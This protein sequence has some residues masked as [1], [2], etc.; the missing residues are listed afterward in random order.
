M[1]ILNARLGQAESRSLT[2]TPRIRPITPASLEGGAVQVGIDV[3]TPAL[4]Q[5]ANDSMGLASP[6]TATFGATPQIGNTLIAV[7]FSRG[8]TNVPVTPSGWT[9]HAEGEVIGA[10]FDGGRQ[11]FFYKTAGASESVN[12]TI[13]TSAT[14]KS[15]YIAEWSGLGAPDDAVEVNNVA[16][17]TSMTVGTITPSAARGV[18]FAGFNQSSRQQT[19][20]MTAGFTESYTDIIDASGPSQ[21]FGYHI[22]D[23]FAGPYTA[24]CTSSQSR[25]YG[26]YVLSFAAA[27]NEVVWYP[28]PQANDGDDATSAYGDIAVGPCIRVYLEVERLIYRMELDIGQETAGTTAYELYGTDDASF[29]TS[30]LLGTLTFTATGGVHAGLNRPVVGA[31]RVVPVLRDTARLG[32]WRRARSLRAADVLVGVIG[33]WRHRSPAA[34]G[35][36]QRGD[37]HPASSVTVADGDEW[38]DS[39]PT[40]SRRGWPSWRPR[41]SAIPAT[42]T[43]AAPRRSTRPSAGT[44]ARLT[45]TAR[46]P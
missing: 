13:S 8:T 29:A 40:T 41:P 5:E 12:V 33:R 45:R 1:P 32:R 31:H 7:L 24:T 16:A 17:T 22:E 14:T 3:G 25:G 39:V 27:A 18:L 15:L 10:G 35:A 20:T 28:A 37:Q 21:V 6:I 4:V 11:T 9:R 43:S 19:L 46:S 2:R 30:T 42:A 23:P 38:F 34:V 36:R 44:R 26:A